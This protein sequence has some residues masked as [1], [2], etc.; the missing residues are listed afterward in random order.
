M[1]QPQHHRILGR[2]AQQGRLLDNFLRQ[3]HHMRLKI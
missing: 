2:L 1:R 3:T